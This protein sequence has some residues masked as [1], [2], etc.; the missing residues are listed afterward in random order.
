[1][2]EASTILKAER[3]AI[4][5]HSNVLGGLPQRANRDRIEAATSPDMSVIRPKAEVI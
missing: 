2:A 1:M 3:G 4:V 5:R